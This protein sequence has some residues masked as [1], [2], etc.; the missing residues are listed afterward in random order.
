VSKVCRVRRL[1]ARAG[2]QQSPPSRSGTAIIAG[3]LGMAAVV[4]LV[5]RRRGRPVLAGPGDDK[6]PGFENPTTTT[7]GAAS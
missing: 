4:W 1:S 5:A 2:R 6:P 3:I 7:V